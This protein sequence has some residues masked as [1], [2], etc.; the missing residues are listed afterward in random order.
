MLD[1]ILE[2]RQAL[3]ELGYLADSKSKFDTMDVEEVRGRIAR[4]KDLNFHLETAY[5]QHEAGI[6][7]MRKQ[8][9]EVGDKIH[10]IMITAEGQRP[11]A[12]KLE[13]V[14]EDPAY[15]ARTADRE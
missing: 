13:V 7:Q 12:R 1:K 2:A 15:A 10:E 14:N 9:I 8:M 3:A 5:R 11:L 6:S 4:L